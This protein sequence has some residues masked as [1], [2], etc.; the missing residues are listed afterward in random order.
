MDINS[1]RYVLSFGGAAGPGP[2]MPQASSPE[3]R[4]E[5]ENTFVDGFVKS[6]AEIKEELGFDGIDID[7]E[8]SLSTP[9]L[10]AFRKIFKKLHAQGELVSMAPESPILDPGNPAYEGEDPGAGAHNS[11][12]PL[13]TRPSSI[14]SA[15][16]LLSCTTTSSHSARIRPSTSSR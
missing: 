9:L 2:Y 6:Y 11:Y 1:W 3:E 5:I 4:E 15:G 8:S 12:V 13:A 7:V 14:T 16:W 10:S